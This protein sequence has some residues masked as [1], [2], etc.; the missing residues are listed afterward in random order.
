M[1]VGFLCIVYVS[2]T[3]IDILLSFD[4]YVPHLWG[5]IKTRTEQYVIHLLGHIIS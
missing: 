5:S 3:S 2:A 1:W 4:V